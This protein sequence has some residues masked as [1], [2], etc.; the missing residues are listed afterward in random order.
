M[1]AVMLHI[2][3]TTAVDGSTHFPAASLQ[4]K[5][6]EKIENRI[7]CW[8]ITRITGGP[9]GPSVLLWVLTGVSM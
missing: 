1:K 7:A 9:T 6:Q 2:A 8:R 5:P 4:S 3:D